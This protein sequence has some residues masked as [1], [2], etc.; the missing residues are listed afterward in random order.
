MKLNDLPTRETGMPALLASDANAVSSAVADGEP[1]LKTSVKAS[2]VP[3]GM[4]A[5]QSAAAVPAVSQVWV[6]FTSFQPCAASVDLASAMLNGY[7]GLVAFAGGNGLCG[8]EGTGPSATEAE[9]W[10]TPLR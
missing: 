10:K 5:P 8:T 1:L 9:P 2:L 4:P 3:A 6:P 7:G